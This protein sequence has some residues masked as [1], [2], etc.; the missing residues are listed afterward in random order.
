MRVH[1]AINRG[2]ASALGITVPM[3]LLRADEVIQ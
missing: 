1:L 2:T 3:S